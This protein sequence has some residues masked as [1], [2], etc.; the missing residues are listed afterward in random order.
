MGWDGMA[1][2]GICVCMVWLWIP[3]CHGT[4]LTIKN[5]FRD[6][7]HLPSLIQGLSCSFL[8]SSSELSAISPSL[9]PS[10]AHCDTSCHE[11]L[12]IR[13]Q[14]FVQLFTSRVP[15]PVLFKVLKKQG[16]CGV[17]SLPRSRLVDLVLAAKVES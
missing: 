13:S 12:G 11:G 1:W 8:H 16:L 10:G 14:V 17:G 6:G 15:S 4:Y 3:K 7:S 2:H 9:P 5:S